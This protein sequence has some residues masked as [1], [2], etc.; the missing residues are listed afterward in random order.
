MMQTQRHIG[1]R[2]GACSIRATDR[3]N[4]RGTLRGTLRSTRVILGLAALAVAV[5]A[6][7]ARA[8][9]LPGLVA[10][11][12]GGPAAPDATA[13]HPSFK[14]T[15]TVPRLTTPI[16][17]DGELDDPGR[18]QA[19][20]ATEFSDVDPGDQVKPPVE[21]ETW[22]AYDEKNLYVAFIARDDPRAVRVSLCERD[23]IFSDDYF[24]LVLDT[25]GDRVW[26]YEFF[27]N[28]KSGA[29]TSRGDTA[30]PAW[31]GCG[32]DWARMPTSADS[33]RCAGGR[34]ADREPSLA[35]MPRPAPPDGCRSSSSS[36]SATRWSRETPP[37]M[38]HSPTSWGRTRTP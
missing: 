28:W 27:V 1:P 3:A 23:N 12:L 2:P 32:A 24:G 38:P 29:T 31:C 37:S 30:L 17:I 10:P 34:G 33:S 26:G 14:P 18:K 7:A 21:S 20:R 16:L 35:S 8:D 4:L 15:T 9:A 36:S 13:F 6:P 11:I 25:Y 5:V 19:A 22:I